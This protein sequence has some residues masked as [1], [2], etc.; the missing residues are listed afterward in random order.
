MTLAIKS[1]KRR[2]CM[3][4]TN[5][6]LV[7]TILLS[8]CFG[9]FSWST[10]KGADEFVWP[11]W[12]GPSGD[13][14]SK[15]TEWNPK[16]L[17][18]DPK[19][20]WNANVGIGYSNVVI[21][22]N[23]LY[24]MGSGKDYALICIDAITGKQTW[25]CILKDYYCDAQSTPTID[26]EFVY[27]LSGEG[28]LACVQLKNGKLFWKKDLVADYGAV[29][30]FYGFAGS[31]VVVGDLLILTANTSGMAL[32]RETGQLVW[33]SD[34]P[35]ENI[36][37]WD[38]KGTEYSTPVIYSYKGKQY[39]LLY[40]WKGMSSVDVETGK[41]LWLYKWGFYYRCPLVPDPVV[42]DNMIYLA[43][44][45]ENEVSKKRLSTLLEING[46]TPI[47]RWKS[48]ALYSDI[49]S[50]VIVD[51]YVYGCYGGPFSISPYASQRCL[52]LKT[53]KLMWEE[54]MLKGRNSFS[55][56]SANR[57]LI[58]LNSQ[59]SLFIV[60]ASPSGYKEISRCDVRKGEKTIGVFFTP[61]V[62]CNG[63]I[64]CRSTAGDLICIDVEN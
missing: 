14:I 20:L 41:Q 56:T 58:I 15:E 52:E 10:A 11:R 49:T 40:S 24:T 45:I 22:D 4:R 3:L 12:R 63:K 1:K 43:S 28:M 7:V 16:A 25:K 6:T 60:E 50:P 36:E 46:E 53:G 17:D 54:G 33:N 48:S 19:I 37:G 29:R 47:I 38:T 31:P 30:P 23:R 8:I 55:L 21:K 64:Y 61:P 13:G 34:K 9:A 44:D 32:N 62:L 35:P 57:M 2:M 59:G 42:M 39:S 18:G 27:A 51:G 5:R 26:G